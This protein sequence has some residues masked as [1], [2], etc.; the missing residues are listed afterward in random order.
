MQVVIGAYAI[1]KCEG[2]LDGHKKMVN[3]GSAYGRILNRPVVRLLQ[4]SR[5]RGQLSHT[6][7]AF[8]TEYGRMPTFQKGAS[9]HDHN[10]AGFTS[11]VAIEG[12]SGTSI[13][14]RSTSSATGPSRTWQ[15][16]TISTPRFCTGSVSTTPGSPSRRTALND[17]SPSC[18]AT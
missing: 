18:A 13:S 5:D 16:S 10:P 3:Q 8:V 11:W 12:G 17:V 15:V 7:A 6:L 2:N 1:G 9:G 14:G 4:D